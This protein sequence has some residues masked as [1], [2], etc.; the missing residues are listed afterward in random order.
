MSSTVIREVKD[1]QGTIET[2]DGLVIQYH[3]E[4]TEE[5]RGFTYEYHWVGEDCQT[6]VKL[7]DEI[8]SLIDYDIWW[9]C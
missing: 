2:E 1:V 7:T 8:E 3:V 5:P 9:Q 4:V 6:E